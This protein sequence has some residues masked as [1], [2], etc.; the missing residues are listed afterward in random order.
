MECK[1]TVS[2]FLIDLIDMMWFLL[3]FSNNNRM[4]SGGIEWNVNI[5]CLFFNRFNRYDVIS[6]ISNS[7]RMFSGGIEYNVN[8]LC[9][10]L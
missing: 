10:C 9:L 7:N 1:Y 5:V 2:L 4:F 6:N 8:I 3:I